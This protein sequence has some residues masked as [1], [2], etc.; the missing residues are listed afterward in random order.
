MSAS[1]GV[2]LVRNSTHRNIE[3]SLGSTQIKGVE[4][5][6]LDGGQPNGAAPHSQTSIT[7]GVARVGSRYNEVSKTPDPTQSMNQM[8]KV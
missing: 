8:H 2:A 1:K 7:Q 5:Q 4:K 3:R 6:D